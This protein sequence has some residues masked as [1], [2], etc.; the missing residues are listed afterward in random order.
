MR[1][2]KKTYLYLALCVTILSLSAFLVIGKVEANYPEDIFIIDDQTN[3]T[4]HIWSSDGTQIAYL[5]FPDEQVWNGEL[6]IADKYSWCAKLKNRRLIYTGVEC[7]RLEDW[8]G[9]W[10][11]FLMR[12]EQIPSDYNSTY[13]TRELWKIKVDGTEL[14][15][16]T[17]TNTNG[18]R[19]VWGGSYPNMGTVSYG[20]FIPGTDLVYFS[21][22]NGNGWYRPYT[23]KAD[24]SDQ[25][26][27]LSVSPYYYS[28]TVGMS[29]TGNKVL[30]GDATY[31]DNPTRA[32][33]ACNPDGSE[34][35][36]IG[37][38]NYRTVPL[39]LAE[40]DTV[41][42]HFI[43]TRGIE[44][45]P[46]G[47]GNIYAM[48]IDGSNPRT[49]IDD[50]YLNEWVDYHP[51][52]GQALIMRSNRSVDGNIHMF[53]INV[54]GTGITQLTEGPYYDEMPLYSPDGQYIMYRRLPEDTELN[55]HGYPTSS[56]PNPYELVVKRVGPYPTPGFSFLSILL[57]VPVIVLMKRRKKI[58]SQ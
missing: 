30:W 37:S 49:V 11:L 32:L 51:L 36:M 22:H 40:G 34:L 24:G 50:E 54:D 19:T 29:P 47:G 10:I 45:L 16:V 25:W 35:A 8:Q 18:I 41:V 38:F 44:G 13:A 33:M 52:N 9:D 26:N 23:C 43:R 5:K 55:V 6:W 56:A 17:F 57:I 3:I 21:A 58:R 48:D 27:A 1:K 2:Q 39:V 15:Q 20:Q 31:W 14:T 7:P 12:K 42:Y 53:N 28:F 46:P 4:D